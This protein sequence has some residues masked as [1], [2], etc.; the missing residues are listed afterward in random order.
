MFIKPEADLQNISPIKRFYRSHLL[1]CWFGG[2]V[3]LPLVLALYYAFSLLSASLPQQEATI[4]LKGLNA[5]V[6]LKRNEQGVVQ[7]QAKSD[8][9]AFF[10]MGYAHAQDRL[11]QMEVQRRMAAGRLAEVFGKGAVTFDIYVRTLGIYKAAQSSISVQSE[12]AMASLE[13]YAKG[14]NSYLSTT[15]LLP[16]EFII[17][18]IEPDPW[19]PVDT[20]AWV[21][22]FAHSLSANFQGEI[23]N[24][25]LSGVLNTAQ[26]TALNRNLDSDEPVTLSNAELKHLDELAQ[27][28]E[29][30]SQLEHQWHVGG[31]HIGSN[32]WVVG[33]EHTDNQTAVMANDPHLGLELPS[34]W[35]AVDVKGDKLS[36]AGMSLVGIPLVMLGR[37]DNIAW[38]GTNMMADTQD[39]FYERLTDDDKQMYES[40][41]QWH[42]MEVYEEY[43][44]VKADFPSFLREPL[45]PIKVRVRRTENGPVISDLFGEVERPMSLNWVG[46]SSKDSS[47]TAFFDMNYAHDWQSF[48]QAMKAH[49]SPAMNL[50]YSDKQNNI[51]YLAIGKLPVRAK[52]E[53]QFPLNGWQDSD[54]WTGFIPADEMPSGY[55]PEKG[56]FVTANNKVSGSDYPYFI[57]HDWAEPAR[58]E[59]ID[60]LISEKLGK[61]EKLSIADSKAFQLDMIDRQALK[62][63]GQLTSIKTD[64]EALNEMIAKVKNWD[65]S[66]AKDSVGASIFFTWAYHLRNQLFADELK[67][68][69]NKSRLNARLQFIVT[70]TTLEQVIN[71]FNTNSVDWCDNVKTEAVEDCNTVKANALKSTWGDL[72]VL[73]GS[74]IDD[75]QWQEA[76]EVVFAHRPF[77]GVKGLDIF[78]GRREPNGGSTNSVNA[79]GSSYGKN[80]GFTQAFG[81]GF[82]QI[83]Q[84]TPQKTEHWYVN[85]TGQSGNLLSEH[86]DDLIEPY[87]NG[88]YFQMSKASDSNQSVVTLKPQTAGGN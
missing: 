33:P 85:S 39:L 12:P 2:V 11:W 22:M 7:I 15:K 35:Y 25:L 52:G 63:V 34:L 18:G 80:S 74:D 88:E 40:E 45:A 57:S 17:L 62:L 31:K 68:D 66:T 60:A 38:G 41:G 47:Y 79:A 43:I 75:W 4:E 83:I 50:V 5:E 3:F 36:V 24:S 87:I 55:N 56:Y 51:G 10:A 29:F 61:G 84:F 27:L 82:R 72:E 58:A 28:S 76:H 46:N 9:D 32:A 16:T 37:N 59:R 48:K 1:L 67:S 69:W 44:N 78:Y 19:K 26:L 81:A 53:G 49:V 23:N 30:G 54:K 86:Y 77:S 73:I 64:D 42:K 70:S 14:I 20:L 13:A 6:E 21:K 65:G 8:E 71:A